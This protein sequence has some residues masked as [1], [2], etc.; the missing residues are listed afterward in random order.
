M[1]GMNTSSAFLFPKFR[2]AP[3]NTN[4]IRVYHHHEAARENHLLPLLLLFHFQIVQLRKQMFA[5]VISID[6]QQVA[7]IA[8]QCTKNFF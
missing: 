2:T 1:L 4:T 8:T 7:N 5:L 6:I 3:I